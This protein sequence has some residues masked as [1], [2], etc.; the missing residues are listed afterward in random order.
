MRVFQGIFFFIVAFI[1]ACA[2]LLTFMQE[3]FRV[4][5]GAKLLW[6][7][8]PAIPVY[9]YLAGAFALGLLFGFVVFI[10]YYTHQSLAL[11]ESKRE[12]ASLA[13]ELET[14]RASLRSSGS[15]LEE[16]RRAMPAGDRPVTPGKP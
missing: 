4:L 11:R 5:V 9:G 6:Y 12:A 2:I 15:E 16:A 7:R 1:V 3:P 8:T 13:A 10:Y 14:L